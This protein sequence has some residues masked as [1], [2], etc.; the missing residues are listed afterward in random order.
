[1]KTASQ[2]DRQTYRPTEGG[3][4]SEKEK[5]NEREDGRSI[6]RCVAGYCPLV[7]AHTSA[8]IIIFRKKVTSLDFKFP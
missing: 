3:G 1:M 7:C 5:N 4:E 2:T 6:P 8:Q